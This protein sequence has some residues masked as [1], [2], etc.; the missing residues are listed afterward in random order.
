M[1]IVLKANAT[2][3][4]LQT[5]VDR[6]REMGL[7]AH[8]SQGEFRTIIGAIGDESKLR[9][10]RFLGLPFVDTV[11][12]VMRPYKLASLD[13]HPELTVIDV[14]G[15]RFGGT[16]LSVIAGPC[17]VE[18]LEGLVETA[19]RVKSAGAGMLR[20]GAFKPRTSPY[21]FQGLGVE[22]LKILKKVGQ[23]TGLPV[24]TEVLDT[25]DVELVAEY[26]DVIQIGARNMQNFAL[27]TE[28][29]KAHKPILLKRGTAASI[30]DFLM[31][32]EYI[33]AQGNSEVILCERG[34]RSFE[35]SVRNLLDL[36]AIPN[37]RSS[38]HL[39][40]IVDPSH[41]TGRRDLV[42]PMALAAIAAGADGIMVEVHP[43]PQDA[44]C[45]G[46]QQLTLDDF[47]T[48]MAEVSA[49]AKVVGKQVS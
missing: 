17:A 4:D 39:P 42:V 34:V 28:A 10:E 41:A 25:R 45:D 7:D 6:I 47:D 29:G 27:L 21:S 44:L 23:E 36:S 43:N 9:L 18:D 1:I 30:E 19:G 2:G 11:M 22:G 40:V 26:A 33:L 15:H 46:P 24:V 35:P 5:V 13:F 3:E 14:R 37:I 48:L 16:S 12:P 49:I 31:S 32:A 38:S 8:V 20:G